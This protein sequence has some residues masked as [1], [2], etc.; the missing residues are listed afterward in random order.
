MIFFFTIL[1][2]MQYY[3]LHT[4]A[5]TPLEVSRV[6]FWK[7]MRKVTPPP[8]KFRGEHYYAGTH[9][10]WQVYSPKKSSN[11]TGSIFLMRFCSTKSG[12]AS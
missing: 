7:G 11:I 10:Y 1:D 5:A 8:N 2:L 3:Y 4:L 12:N 9:E 6:T